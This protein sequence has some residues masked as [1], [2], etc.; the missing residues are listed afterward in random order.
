MA[1]YA[2][3][4][5][6]EF[7]HG[8]G[9]DDVSMGEFMEML[10][11]YLIWYRDKRRKSDLGN[12]SPMRHRRSLGLVAQEHGPGFPPHSRLANS[13]QLFYIPS[14]SAQIEWQGESPRPWVNQGLSASSESA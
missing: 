13:N 12:M 11:A 9:R 7:F 8:R 2:I 10:D 3:S 5:K 6:L 4:L 1:Q 14:N